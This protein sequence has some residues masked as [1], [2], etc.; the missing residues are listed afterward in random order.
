MASNL[1][2]MASRPEVWSITMI[3][4]RTSWACATC[5]TQSGRAFSMSFRK[6]W[7]KR[8]L[9]TTSVHKI[10]GCRNTTKHV[11]T[12][13]AMDH[14][15]QVAELWTTAFKQLFICAVCAWS[16]GIIVT[17]SSYVILRQ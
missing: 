6:A 17:K 3:Y 1:K 14:C 13:R 8:M 2:A 10:N 12:C 11:K 7:Q 15:F 5:K 9:P 4:C 16:F